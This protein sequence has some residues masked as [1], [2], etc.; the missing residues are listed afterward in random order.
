MGTACVT[1]VEP[2]LNPRQSPTDWAHRREELLESEAAGWRVD[3]QEPSYQ[4]AMSSRLSGR[5]RAA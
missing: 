5:Q 2:I 3:L 1:L 4:R